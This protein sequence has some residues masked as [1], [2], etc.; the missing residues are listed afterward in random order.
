MIPFSAG[1]ASTSR[2]ITRVTAHQPASSSR[3]TGPRRSRS[4]TAHRPG[5][6]SCPSGTAGRV[7]RVAPAGPDRR[8]GGAARPAVGSLTGT[9]CRQPA[10]PGAGGSG[11]QQ[12]RRGHAAPAAGTPAGSAAPGQ[13][14]A[15]LGEPV[16]R[17]LLVAV[18]AAGTDLEVQVIAGALAK[19]ADRADELAGLHLLA[20][21][22]ED[23]LFVPVDR[24]RPVRVL[25]HD[26]V[27][28]PAHRAGLDHDAVAGGVERR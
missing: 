18:P 28:V 3:F 8:P 5:P 21:L 19:V 1:V 25:D 2:V 15:A 11:A 4:R 12:R 17:V 13:R 7:A 23:P 27:A 22:D 20:H 9:W 26:H 6:G 14:D 10:T 24:D 16:D